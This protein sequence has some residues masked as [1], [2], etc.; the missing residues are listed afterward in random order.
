MTRVRPDEEMIADYLE[1]RLSDAEREDL[2]KRICDHE[3][4]LEGF[5]VA[6]SVVRSAG[7]SDLKP[8]PSGV[9][10][11]AKHLVSSRVLEATPSMGERLKHF[12][13]ELY[14]KLSLTGPAPWAQW[15][16]ASIRGPRKVVS[17][18]LARVTKTFK[19]IKTEIEIE[20]V[21]PNK[22]YV[23]IILLKNNLDK[24]VRVTLKRRDRE[25]SSQLLTEDVVL[26]EDI[27][28]GKYNLIFFRNS[29]ELGTYLFEIRES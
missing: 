5:V 9:T 2:E 14:S 13:K 19:E 20:K 27:P 22:S 1:G 17:K 15:R 7:R 4:W 23:R 16:F 10:Q 8:I 25:V 29:D 18:D 24:T 12:L 11:T 21:G 26:F 28:F 3:E 6:G